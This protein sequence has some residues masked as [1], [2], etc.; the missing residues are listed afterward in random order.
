S[1]DVGG[2]KMARAYAKRFSAGL[3]IIDKRRDSPEKTEVM[4]ILGEVERKNAIIVDD[5][6]AT[7]S[8]LIE[9]VLALKRAKAKSIHAAISHGVLSGPA[10]ERLD[11]CKELEELIITD[12][13]PLSNHKRHSRIKVL[14]IAGL[15]GEAIRRIHNEESVS[16]LFD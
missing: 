1:P 15:L 14:S 4:H 10:I 13:I 6:V 11:K 16:S 5:L 12:S 7:G 3:S 8:S 9:A 2:I